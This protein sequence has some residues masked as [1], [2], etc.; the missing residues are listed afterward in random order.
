MRL[1]I[2]S[3]P[4]ISLAS[5]APLDA[6]AAQA[7]AAWTGEARALLDARAALGALASGAG[8]G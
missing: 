1:A 2:A 5:L 8:A 7:M 3:M 6:A 4:A